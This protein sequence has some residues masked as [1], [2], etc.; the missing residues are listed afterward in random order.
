MTICTVSDNVDADVIVGVKE[1]KPTCTWYILNTLV[2]QNSSHMDHF[3]LIKIISE[4]IIIS[5]LVQ[6]GSK[7]TIIKCFELKWSWKDSI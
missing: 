2:V 6:A 7:A 3:S 4:I 5:H 1:M